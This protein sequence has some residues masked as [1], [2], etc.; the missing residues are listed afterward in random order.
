MEFRELPRGTSTPNQNLGDVGDIDSDHAGHPLDG[1]VSELGSLDGLAD[2]GDLD[3]SL[4]SMSSHKLPNRDVYSV[5]VILT[6]EYVL[7]VPKLCLPDVSDT[8]AKTV[9]VWLW[10]TPKREKIKELFNETLVPNNV[11]GLLPVRI[12]KALYQRLPFK[13]K[14][15]DQKLWG[16][17]TFLTRGLGPILSVL[18]TLLAME[19]FMANKGNVKIVDQKLHLDKLVVDCTEL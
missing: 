11:S 12:N 7:E 3:G 19:A 5:D 16:I 17:N 18:D 4:I 10:D 9:T 15:N 1:E 14:V 13:G 6:K 8:L 2:E